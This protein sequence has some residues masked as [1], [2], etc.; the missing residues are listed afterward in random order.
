M[1]MDNNDGHSKSGD[2]TF[3]LDF[4]PVA[5]SKSFIISGSTGIDT[6]ISRC[7]LTNAKSFSIVL[8]RSVAASNLRPVIVNILTCSMG[9]AGEG[10]RGART[11]VG[12]TWESE[13]KRRAVCNLNGHT[14][15]CCKN[16]A[17]IIPNSQ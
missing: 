4:C 6:T 14:Q 13:V 3:E 16:R 15:S 1:M 17:L 2:P 12:R 5:T 8:R 9:M 7:K 10:D 11:V